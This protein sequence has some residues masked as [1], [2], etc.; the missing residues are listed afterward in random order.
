MKQVILHTFTKSEVESL[1][2]DRFDAL[3]GHWPQLWN[4]ELKE[5][6]DSL[7]LVV[8]GYDDHPE[9]IYCIPE[10]RRFY[11]ELHK[12]WPWW[13]FFLSNEMACM[14]ICYLC[15]IPSVESYKRDGQS[16]CAAA[17]EPKDIL[18][19]LHHDFGR[20][21]YLWGIAGM[22]DAEN[23]KRSDEILKLFTGGG[24]NG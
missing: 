12:R 15:L 23:D 19:I 16:Q 14:A 6:F 7:V 10:V 5:K 2:F 3:Y 20:M 18:E 9:E 13:A 11:R 4:R 22:S 17:F 21:N 24:R 8:D 1:D